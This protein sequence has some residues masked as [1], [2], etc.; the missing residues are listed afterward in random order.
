MAASPPHPP[1]R[2]WSRRV[3]L[4]VL[5]ALAVLSGSILAM[6]TN[7]TGV[8]ANGYCSGTQ[9]IPVTSA[10]DLTT[11]ASDATCLNKSF[12]Q[13]QDIPVNG[14]LTPIGSAAPFTGT[15]DGGDFT[16]S[17]ATV[18]GGGFFG[19]TNNATIRNLIV[20]DSAIVATSIAG[21]LIGMGYST[22]VMD[23]VL[24]NIR[25]TTSGSFAGGLIGEAGSLDAAY[26]MHLSSVDVCVAVTSTTT[27]Y[28]GGLMGYVFAN[29]GLVTISASSAQGSL[30][31]AGNVG[32][33]VGFASGGN[34]AGITV[35]DSMSLI[36]VT[37][38]ANGNVAGAVGFS[39]PGV[40]GPVKIVRSYAA[41]TVV[42]RG[43][44]VGGLVA[45]SS[46]GGET[47]A[48]DSYWDLDRTSQANSVVGAGKATAEMKTPSTYVSWPTSVWRLASGTYPTLKRGP[49]TVPSC[50]LGSYSGDEP[51]QT[52]TVAVV[53]PPPASET[54]PSTTV[55]PSEPVGPVVVEAPEAGVVPV[56]VSADDADALQRSPGV[57]DIIVDGRPVATEV[58]RV[59][60]PSAEVA[61][62]DR[63]PAQVAAMQRAGQQLVDSFTEAAP[64]G[65]DPLV[66]LTK[67]ATGAVVNGVAVDPRDGATPVPVPVEDVVLVKA[68]ETRVL[69]AAIGPDGT[70]LETT[71]GVLKTT[72]R[73]ALS[74]IAYGLGAGAPGELVLFSSPTLLGSF[75]TDSD[76]T[77]AGQVTLPADVQAGTHTL[78]LTAGGITTTL[79]VLVDSEGNA[80]IVD[81]TDTGEVTDTA[82][83]VPESNQLPSTG[84]EPNIVMLLLAVL[85]VALGGVLASRRR[86]VN[87]S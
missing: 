44:N 73:G 55:A 53:L 33:L 1:S 85:L 25:V 23:V 2:S 22:A 13:T 5:G 4:S 72:R 84:N 18:S 74:A 71:G 6:N 61:P 69:L 34:V 65:S 3:V 16:I 60:I 78:V 47:S 66:T 8:H 80:V 14:P 36:D 70:P 30:N 35:E 32:G 28:F 48:T 21:G 67:T 50:G 83:S 37:G 27:G 63:S 9:P 86:P 17:N 43:A 7:V 52:D 12:I 20:A 38:S 31:G 82:V 62:E 39:D 75:T 40:S 79:G 24:R 54:T 15:Y 59:E 76:G 81:P 64:T 11:I 10:A 29:T 26:P 46:S 51:V 45:S 57:G 42:A 77:F 56:L 41:G 19:Y 87:V 49:G 68:G 58:V